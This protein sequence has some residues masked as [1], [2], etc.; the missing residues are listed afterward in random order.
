MVCSQT[1]WPSKKVGEKS[2]GKPCDECAHSLAKVYKANILYFTFFINFVL[3][4]CAYK[5]PWQEANERVAGRNDC[6]RQLQLF[7]CKLRQQCR[8]KKVAE[9]TYNAPGQ[10]S[11]WTY[12]LDKN[13]TH[14]VVY[15]M[16]NCV[17]RATS[18]V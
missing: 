16:Q 5:V 4:G 6:P 13:W 15:K 11:L 14:I 3:R 9:E 7:V 2:Q 18:Y 10:I 17:I 8:R 1:A 12:S